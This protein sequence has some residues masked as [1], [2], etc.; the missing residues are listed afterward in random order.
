MR[1]PNPAEANIPLEG[2][3]WTVAEVA[4]KLRCSR[5]H[6]HNLLNGKVRGTEKLVSIRLGR[7]R[8]VCQLDLAHFDTQIWPPCETNSPCYLL[9]L[10][11]SVAPAGAK[12]CAAAFAA[13]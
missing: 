3:I 13:R 9:S 1:T 8:C 7:R 4:H 6:V 2:E 10:L 12:P 5:A 11:F